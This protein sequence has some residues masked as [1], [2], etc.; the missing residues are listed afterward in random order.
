MEVTLKRF[1]TITSDSSDLKPQS[2][3]WKILKLFSRY[4]FLGRLLCTLYLIY[5]VIIIFSW[6]MQYLLFITTTNYSSKPIGIL[7][8]I[9]Y[10]IYGVIISNAML[11]PLWD[12]LKLSFVLKANCFNNMV[13][14][15]CRVI[16]R[17]VPYEKERDS[18]VYNTDH[19]PLFVIIINYVL[20]LI[21]V[22]WFILM[23]IAFMNHDYYN[24][25][26]YFNCG[27]ICLSLLY[28]LVLQ[29]LYEVYF[30]KKIIKLLFYKE[31]EKLLPT[32]E[33][34]IKAEEE[35]DTIDKETM[36]NQ[37]R[38]INSIEPQVEST[39][40]HKEEEV[41]KKNIE[42]QNDIF[43]HLFDHTYN[44]IIQLKK[45]GK[46]V[47]KYKSIIVISLIQ[48]IAFILLFIS[49][50]CQSHLLPVLTWIL[51][52][53]CFI[54][55]L[56]PSFTLNYPPWITIPF[57]R[58]CIS[59]KNRKELMQYSYFPILSNIIHFFI[60]LVQIILFILFVC[61]PEDKDV[62]HAIEW[63]PKN[64]TLTTNSFF[65]SNRDI[66]KPSFCFTKAHHLS[67]IQL[68]AIAGD[69]Y[70][71]MNN[72]TNIEYLKAGFFSNSDL[73][74]NCKGFIT[75]R[76][77]I[78]AVMIR[79]D[80]DIPNSTKNVSVFAIRGTSNNIDWWLDFQMFFSTALFTVTKNTIPIL[81]KVDSKMYELTSYLFSWPLRYFKELSL[82]DRYV[83][84]LIQSFI[85][86]YDDYSDR[87]II[88]VGHSLGGGLAK[89]MGKRFN[90]LAVS[91]SGPG[92]SIF[93]KLWEPT[94]KEEIDS[95]YNENFATSYIDIVPD[96][97]LVPRVE[98]SGGT[99]YRIICDA[100]FGCHSSSRSICMGSIMC[101]EDVDYICE[102]AY[103]F[104]KS[105]LEHMKKIANITKDIVIK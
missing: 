35:M 92:I 96:M 53:G 82:I 60:L 36:E 3:K 25:F 5:G 70:H 75:K 45:T 57:A 80:I 19:V 8:I 1:V 6:Q 41:K 48:L 23:V 42:D 62:V 98:V 99:N 65:A 94:V 22:A 17:K 38:E 11:L 71:N 89:I 51:T 88:F 105:E 78:G 27:M 28:L 67:I 59:Q 76:D 18:N 24:A 102:K 63:P 101:N 13:Y 56:I 55:F 39:N 46:S 44:H 30:I 86:H 50:I 91:L 52:L 9:V 37:L 104:S 32:G 26:D 97:D 85:D 34:I 83:D 40:E 29:F 20:T 49:L 2:T 84:K 73:I 79:Y 95:K 43:L 81:T 7:Y 4:S 47:L 10:T 15:V 58:C 14:L 87:S 21:F 103:K 77:D 31:T 100:G 61:F 54:L 68:M 72:K 16:D 64:Q 33:E 74:I 69:A 93:S 90:K 12:F 66:I